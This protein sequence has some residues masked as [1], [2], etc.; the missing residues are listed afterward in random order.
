MLLWVVLALL[1]V[2]VVYVYSIAKAIVFGDITAAWAHS[3]QEY[4][5]A[6]D[7]TLPPTWSDFVEWQRTKKP[8]Y[9]ISSGEMEMR[10]RIVERDLRKGTDSTRYIEVIDPDLKGME[11]MINRMVRA[12]APNSNNQKPQGTEVR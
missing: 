11:G 4:A 5:I 10:F 1:T 9:K 7:A 3:V 6:H 12:A 8:E 2:A